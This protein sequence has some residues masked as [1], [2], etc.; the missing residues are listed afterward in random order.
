MAR[1]TAGSNCIF[2]GR[3][4]YNEMPYYLAACDAGVAPFGR[5]PKHLK[6]VGF[7][8]SPMKIFEYLAM[9]LPVITADYKELRAIVGGA[10]IFYKSGDHNALASAIIRIS[11]KRI[12]QNAS[13]AKKYSWDAQAKHLESVLEGVL[14][15]IA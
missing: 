6:G 1:K 11:K 8:W 3:K 14:K 10:G 4:D 15:E 5:L 7:Y 13:G 9:G 2:A 12:K